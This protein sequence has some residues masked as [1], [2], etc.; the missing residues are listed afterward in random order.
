MV[1]SKPADKVKSLGL[2]SEE[3]K[4][5]LSQHGP[6]ELEKKK[7]FSLP[8]L[9]FS[10]FTSPLIYILFIAG[11]ITLFLN[12]WTDAVVIFL[13]VF[14]NAVLG[15]TQEFKAERAL[16]ALKKIL[17]SHAKVIRDGKESLVE[18]S[19]LVPGDLIILSTGD[20]VPAEGK[21]QEAV[22]L[23]INEA[24]L[25][26]ESTPAAKTADDEAFMGTVVVSGRGKM[27]VE[28]TGKATKMGKIASKLSQTTE[29]ETP[30]KKQ[31][32]HFS[33]TLAIIFSVICIIIFF[34]GLW[35]GKEFLEIFTLSVAVAVAAIP[36]GLVVSLTVILTLGMQRILKRKGLVR[37]LLAA[38]TLGSVN[39]ICSDKTG[40]L[41]E[42]KM[43]VVSASFINKK[44][45]IRAAILCNNMTNPLEIAM[46]TWAKDEDR[47]TE[48]I[49]NRT[50]RLDE[51]PFSSERKFI[52]VLN[53]GAKKGRQ[54]IFLSGAPEMVLEMVKAS[55]RDK[56]KWRQEL[57]EHTKKGLRVVAFAWT[58]ASKTEAKKKFLKLKKQAKKYNG[59]LDGDWDCLSL[60]WLGLLLFEDPPR[61]EVKESLR[62]CRQAGIEVKVITG[63]YKNTAIAILNKLDLFTD[64]VSEEQVLEG[65]QLEKIS[66]EELIKRIDDV[67]LFC[68]TTPEQKIR[69]VEA[70]QNQGH[71]V[72]MMGDG[73]NDALAVKKA[74]IGVVVGEASEVAKETAD[75]VLL[76]SNFNTIVAAVEEGRGIFEN[77]R[78]VILYLLSSSFTETILIGGSLL[79]GLPLPVTAVQILWVNLIQDGLPDLALAFE[80]IE[81]SLMQKP[82]RKKSKSILDLELKVLIFIV[83]LVTDF[84]LL[85]LF[86]WLLKIDLNLKLTQTIIFAALGSNA[87]FYVFSCKSL[88]QN[89]WH[90]NLLNNKFLLLAVF[91]G[92]SFMLGALYLPFLQTFLST[93]SLSPLVLTGIFILGLFNV[94][95]IEI[96]KWLFLK[97]EKVA[98]IKK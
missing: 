90:T 76:D 29:D 56:N 21:L 74:D 23:H 79:L 1:K 85:G 32:G 6:N 92:F 35:R 18:I 62:L 17:V 5:R 54:E 72:A 52:A 7:P 36:E 44:A 50:K 2:S 82:P 4:A 25:T 64:K 31:I 66:Q 33:K 58:E 87:L 14:V 65:W 81:K 19:Q 86:I 70:L 40:T 30:L 49:L 75:M 78:K 39:V 13:A 24:I 38:E 12:E 47:S 46:M 22:D 83:G 91:L 37:K 45:G 84:I 20:K 71:I 15:F 88:Q 3:A 8:K 41:T 77:I 27:L 43:R 48:E 93:V 16:E 26:G 89:I 9:I 34:E 57:D 95:L 68:R 11:V 63:D 59:R 96:V 67:V 10:Q 60:N 94:V 28:K 51:I 73:V 98:I 55:K 61:K 80:P 42:G 69:I 53:K 97:Q